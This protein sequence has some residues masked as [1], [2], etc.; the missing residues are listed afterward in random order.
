[1]PQEEHGENSPERIPLPTL[2]QEVYDMLST[3]RWK[4]PA[5]PAQYIR[6]ITASQTDVVKWCSRNNNPNTEEA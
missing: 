3:G 1:M 2:T 5:M 6:K 4:Q